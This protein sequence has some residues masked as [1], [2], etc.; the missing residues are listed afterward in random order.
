MGLLKG[1]MQRDI[2]TCQE[3]FESYPMQK[4]VGKLLFK[5]CLPTSLLKAYCS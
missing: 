4:S 5:Y 3:I 2:T 1:G